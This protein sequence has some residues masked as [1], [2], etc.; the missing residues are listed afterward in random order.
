MA[1]TKTKPKREAAYGEPPAPEAWKDKK[2]TVEYEAKVKALV[3]SAMADA[4]LSYAQLA[5]KLRKKGIEISDKGLEN[6]IARG[7]FSAPF[8]LQCLDALGVRSV[9]LP[10]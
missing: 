3:R 9:D 10:G 4:G 7:S 8:L 2:I 6:K 5:G 1:P